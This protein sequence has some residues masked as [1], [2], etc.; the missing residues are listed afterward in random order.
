MST[1]HRVCLL[2]GGSGDAVVSKGGEIVQLTSARGPR[3]FLLSNGLVFDFT[4]ASPAASAPSS[5]LTGDAITSDG[6]LLVGSPVDILFFL[7]SVLE[8]GSA[9]WS[10]ASQLIAGAGSDASVLANASG[11]WDRIAA[12]CDI[13]GQDGDS[14]E[15][16]GVDSETLVRLN[17]GK[18]LALLTKKV[19][20]VAVALCAGARVRAI[21]RNANT[22]GFSVESRAGTAALVA[23][24]GGGPTVSPTAISGSA[25]SPTDTAATFFASITSDATS[26]GSAIGGAATSPSISETFNPSHSDLTNALAIMEDFISDTWVAAVAKE[27]G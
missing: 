18:A 13:Y 9:R 1:M 7:L 14:K 6:A 27:L 25:G 2:S 26:S 20:R 4:R 15:G 10:S 22:G 8:T 21:A 3:S 17:R 12:V 11:V 23:S 24:G 16:G 5:W 19:R